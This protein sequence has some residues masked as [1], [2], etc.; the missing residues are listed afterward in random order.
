M[1][2]AVSSSAAQRNSFLSPI[3]ITACR[4]DVIS[5]FSPKP[6][7]LMMRIRLNASPASFFSTSSMSSVLACLRT[8]LMSSMMLA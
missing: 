2:D 1:R 3:N 6:A 5:R 8:W 4:K 7:E